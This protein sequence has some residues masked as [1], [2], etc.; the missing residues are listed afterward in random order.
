MN[1][2]TG[3]I[4]SLVV[5]CVSFLLPLSGYGAFGLF[6][7]HKSVKSIDG[8]VHIPVKDVSDGEAHYYLYKNSGNKVKFFLVKS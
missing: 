7:Q 6:G 8:E 2:N 4:F 5:L 1:R 3:V